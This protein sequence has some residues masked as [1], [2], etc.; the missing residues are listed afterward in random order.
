LGTQRRLGAEIC[1]KQPQFAR[2]ALT[3]TIGEKPLRLQ[4]IRGS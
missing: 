2:I 1:D 3:T 4:D